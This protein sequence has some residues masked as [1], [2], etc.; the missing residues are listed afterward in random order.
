MSLEEIRN[1]F[2]SDG[3]VV[4]K[5]FFPPDDAEKYHK[6]FYNDMPKDWWHMSTYFG[7]QNIIRMDK[8][9]KNKKEVIKLWKEAGQLINQETLSYRF[10]RTINHDSKCHCENCNIRKVFNSPKMM[11]IIN[12]ISEENVSTTHAMFASRY[13]EGCYLSTHT[14]K[15]NGKIA[16]VYNLSKNWRPCWG[17]MLHFLEPDCVSVRNVIL[18]IFNSLTIFRVPENGIPHFVSQVS[19]GVTAERI[20]VSGWFR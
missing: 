8:S 10:W 6:F 14:D 12:S 19:D 5:D 2:K 1:K 15:G 17:A 4:I 11:S 7:K 13:T 16:F 9:H 3:F 18:P 20:A